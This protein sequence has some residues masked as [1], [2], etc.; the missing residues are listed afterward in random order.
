MGNEPGKVGQDQ[1]VKDIESLRK[2]LDFI[3]QVTA[4]SDWEHIAWS[5]RRSELH[6]RREG[7]LEWGRGWF[8][9]YGLVITQG[10]VSWMPEKENLSAKD[11]EKSG[12]EWC[13][14]N[15]EGVKLT[16]ILRRSVGWEIT[17]TKQ[18]GRETGVFN[19]QAG[20]CVDVSFKH[21]LSILHYS[22]RS[23]CALGR[24]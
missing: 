9:K 6:P 17:V 10:Q 24:C 7:T 4:I 22:L 19:W 23:Y 13:G 16:T 14:Q 20:D 1:I 12:N 2:S 5:S 11:S 15:I 21:P 3:W 18:W 8:V